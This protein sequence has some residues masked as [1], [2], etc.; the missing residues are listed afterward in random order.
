MQIQIHSFFCSNDQVDMHAH[1]A[2]LNGC[3]VQKFC[4]TF[5]WYFASSAYYCSTAYTYVHAR[6]WITST[7]QCM[8]GIHEHKE[9]TENDY[10]CPPI[11]LYTIQYSSSCMSHTAN[12]PC[13]WKLNGKCYRL[14]CIAAGRTRQFT[15]IAIHCAPLH[16]CMC[17]AHCDVFAYLDVCGNLSSKLVV[18]ILYVFWRWQK[19]MP[20]E[21]VRT[22][23]Y[24]WVPTNRYSHNRR[25]NVRLLSPQLHYNNW[26]RP[27]RL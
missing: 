2:T 24:Y 9:E 19:H 22:R 27:A 4:K 15:S 23:N 1:N 10:M 20:N 16:V 17:C 12:V 8:N 14:R 7:L 18:V 26:C 25:W 21:W 5:S 3:S 13:V 11:F 6:L